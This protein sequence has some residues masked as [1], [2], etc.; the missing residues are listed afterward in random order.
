MR[1]VPSWQTGAFTALELPAARPLPIE[2]STAAAVASAL[3]VSL[4]SL[5]GWYANA[6][7][8]SPPHGRANVCSAVYGVFPDSVVMSASG[9]PA[10][11]SAPITT[12]VELASLGLPGLYPQPPSSFCTDLRKPTPLSTTSR[13]TASSTTAWTAAAVALVSATVFASQGLEASR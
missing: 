3:A 11:A 2:P 9:T 5:S 6:P 8:P 1:P 7:P 12:A 10:R 4:P 13:C